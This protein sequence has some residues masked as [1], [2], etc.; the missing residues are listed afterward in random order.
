MV[1]TECPVSWSRCRITLL[2]M[3]PAP[4]VTRIRFMCLPK[5]AVDVVDRTLLDISL[6]AGEVLAQHGHDE[7]LQPQH[8]QHQAAEEERAREVVVT[9]PEHCSPD[10][11]HER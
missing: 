1:T 6:D 4:P 10:R 7:P 3:K 8:E 5:F 9:D 2:E 11:H